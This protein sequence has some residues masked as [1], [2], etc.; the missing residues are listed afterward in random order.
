MSRKMQDAL[1][2]AG[3]AV[4][5]LVLG[6][7]VAV[8]NDVTVLRGTDEAHAIGPPRS[9]LPAPK[10]TT[11]PVRRGLARIGRRR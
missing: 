10:V 9:S 7:S 2:G 3:I 5:M 1:I 11:R 6:M 4:L 8:A